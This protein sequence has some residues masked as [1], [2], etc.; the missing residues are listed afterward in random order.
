MSQGSHSEAWSHVAENH[1]GSREVGHPE[2]ISLGFLVEQTDPRGGDHSC[3]DRGACS[4]AEV[5]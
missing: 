3:L 5:E 4:N 2:P 1:K